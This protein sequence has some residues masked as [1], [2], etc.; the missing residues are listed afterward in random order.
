MEMQVQRALQNR[1]VAIVIAIVAGF[2]GVWQI[3]NVVRDVYYAYYFFPRVKGVE[4]SYPELRYTLGQAATLLW[5]IMGV[6]TA[7]LAGRCAL[8]RRD[9]KWAARSTIAFVLGFIL[10]IVGSIAG[11]AIRDLGF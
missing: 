1:W 4:Y 9:V 2:V 6:C 7:A 11:A 3:V 5:A 10:L 8:L